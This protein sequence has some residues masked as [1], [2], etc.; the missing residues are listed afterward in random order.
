MKLFLFFHLLVSPYL[1][2]DQDVTTCESK[3]SKKQ[4]RSYEGAKEYVQTLGFKTA[5]QFRAWSR[6]DERPKDFPLHPRDVYKSEWK[7]WNEFLGTENVHKKKFRSYEAGQTLMKELGIRTYRQFQKWSQSDERPD[8]FPSRP[9]QVYKSKWKSWPIFLGTGNVRKKQFRSYESAQALMRELGIRTHEQFRE[10]NRADKRP[11]DFPS[12][13]DRVYK[14]KWQNWGVFLG[15]GNI[16]KKTFRSY[17]SAQAL[18]RELSIRTRSQFKE[19]NRVGKRPNDIPANPNEVYKSKWKGWNA[20][21]GKKNWMSYEAAQALMQ[22]L[23]IKTVRQFKEWNRVGK[24][25]NDIPANPNEV[26]KS[27]WKGW[28]AFFGKKNWMS[29]EAAQALMQGLGIKTVRQFKEWRRSSERPNKFPANP[30]EVYK[31]KWKGWN[32]FFGK[33]SWRSYESARI[34]MERIGI[35]TWRQFQEW[36]RSGKRPEDFPSHPHD[37]YKSEWKG[38]VCIFRAK[39]DELQ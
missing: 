10:W 2:A 20:F 35:K 37:V 34:L 17:E 31:S 27:K 12:H 16:Y 15:T 19:W 30:N 6:S 5:Q 1:F 36:S 38:W 32:A 7:N 26:Y 4:W 23:G 11:N 13:P 8:D 9:D 3:F 14:F 39:V 29:Y 33:R 18:M 21:F 22:G 24:R 25:P 28:N